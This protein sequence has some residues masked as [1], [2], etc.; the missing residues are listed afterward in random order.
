VEESSH[1]LNAVLFRHLLGGSQGGDQNTRYWGRGLKPGS[2]E[3]RE[4]FMVVMI[5]AA[6]VLVFSQRCSLVS[7]HYRFGGIT[8]S[9]LMVKE[10]TLKSRTVLNSSSRRNF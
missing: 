8:A 4:V 3:I 5:H 7:G 10:R 9:I 2:S 1:G 6:S